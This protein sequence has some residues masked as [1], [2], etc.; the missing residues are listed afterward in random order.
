MA[1]KLK[2]H[3]RL[4]TCLPKLLNNPRISKEIKNDLGKPGAKLLERVKNRNPL[5]D[6]DRDTLSDP[7]YNAYMACAKNILSLAWDGDAPGM[8]GALSIMECEGIYVITSS[9]FDELGP[10]SS[11]KRALAGECFGIVTANPQLNSDVLPTKWL[12]EIAGQVVDWENEGTIEINSETYKVV[13]DALIQDSL[14][15]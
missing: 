5:D 15:N 6:A 2:F 8:S 14:S 1:Q 10:F 11:L 4:L 9:D 7:V 3:D 13:G 12:L